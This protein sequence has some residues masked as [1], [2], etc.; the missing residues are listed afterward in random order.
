MLNISFGCCR[1][2][3]S[4]TSVQLTE[5]HSA[6]DKPK[7]LPAK[8]KDPN[9]LHYASKSCS[10]QNTSTKIMLSRYLTIRRWEKNS[11]KWI[12]WMEARW[13]GFSFGLNTH[14]SWYLP[15]HQQALFLTWKVSQIQGLPQLSNFES[16]W[17]KIP[18]SKKPTKHTNKVYHSVPAS[19]T[20]K[21]SLQLVLT[22]SKW[23][24]NENLCRFSQRRAA[25]R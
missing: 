24:L 10:R 6:R 12:G 2:S 13:M 17:K 25:L 19:W 16:D 23:Q 21:D 7:Q 8:K 1:H 15:W 18:G 11:S 14:H 4:N 5:G 9:K 3:V 20:K 22:T